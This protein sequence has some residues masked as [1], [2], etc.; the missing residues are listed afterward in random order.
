[1]LVEVVVEERDNSR[2]EEVV[3]SLTGED[4]DWTVVEV[5]NS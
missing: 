2:L 3:E 1:M 4:V 5:V